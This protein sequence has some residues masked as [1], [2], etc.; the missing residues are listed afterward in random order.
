M[1]RP[2]DF[3]K[4]MRPHQWLKNGFVFTG[5]LFGHAWNDS[6]LVLHIL[7]AFAGFSLVA[8]SI[9]TFNDLLDK[10]QDKRHPEK[11]N[12]PLAA[13]RI[14]TNAAIVWSLLLGV[15]G[16]SF[17]WFASTTVLAILVVYAVIN[18]AYSYRLK[19]VVILDVFIIASGF[20]LRILAGTLGVDIPPSTWLLL[21]GMMI[22]LFLGFAKRHAEIQMLES[23][24]GKHRKVL[25][26][27]SRDMLDKFLVIT[28]AC[29]IMSYSLYTMSVDT[30]ATQ[31]TENLIYTVPFIV[32]A[33][34]RYILVLQNGRGGSDPARDLPR[35]PHIVLSVIG[36]LVTTLWMITA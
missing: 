15:A 23:G 26:Y 22:T 28:A 35:D 1:N 3:F 33:I 20:M 12:R 17:G 10:N 25:A 19:H 8:S 29:V 16:F 2:L 30:I 18:V 11:K 27:Y 7:A 34:F 5:L 32:Y 9:Y 6:Q 14:T 21:C 4:L 31:G 36:W 13:G 24:S